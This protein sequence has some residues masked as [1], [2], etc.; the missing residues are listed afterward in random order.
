MKKLLFYLILFFILFLSFRFFLFYYGIRLSYQ[1]NKGYYSFQGNLWEYVKEYRNFIKKHRRGEDDKVIVTDMLNRRFYASY[2]NSFGI[3]EKGIGLQK[4]DNAYRIIC[5]GSSYTLTGSEGNRFTDLLEKKLN[6]KNGEGKFEII[7]AGI[8]G[9]DILESFMNFSLNWRLLNPDIVI[10][11]N[12]LDDIYLSALP[13]YLKNHDKLKKMEIK[14]GSWEGFKNVG[15]YKIID[16]IFSAF[17]PRYNGPTEEGL[18]CYETILESLVLL[19]K[20]MGSKVVLL[21]CGIAVDKNHNLEANNPKRK[22]LEL[23]FHRFTTNGVVQIIE[24]Y[25]NIMKKVA[26]KNNAIFID[27]SKVVPKDDEHFLDATHRSDEGN[28]IFAGALINKL[29]ALGLFDKK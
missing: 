25:N 13:F 4:K 10:I 3:K 22:M 5:L 17:I 20:G 16:L 21:S 2:I 24:E 15:K 8:P 11:D 26:D 12:V 9:Q 18:A 29:I 1:I 7:N 23:H 19:A 14:Y 27:M 6:D 28:E